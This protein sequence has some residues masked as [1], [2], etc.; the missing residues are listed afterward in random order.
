MCTMESET[1]YWIHSKETRLYV[2]MEC[3]HHYLTKGDFNLARIMMYNEIWIHYYEPKS[4]WQQKVEASWMFGQKKI[5]DLLF[6]DFMETRYTISRDCYRV[7]LLE[8]E[9]L[10]YIIILVHR[11]QTQPLNPLKILTGR[12]CLIHL[13]PQ[14]LP[15]CDYVLFGPPCSLFVS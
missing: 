1:A 14:A 7:M 4:K 2:Y 12:F 8:I 3:K 9:W 6:Y 15:P 5:K 11:L 10:F 13:V